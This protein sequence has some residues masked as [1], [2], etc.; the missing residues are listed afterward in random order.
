MYW[1]FLEGGYAK[2]VRKGN[3]KY[4]Y[5]KDKKGQ[6]KE[7]LFDL[8]NDPSEAN[9]VSGV[10]ED[11]FRELQLLGQTMHHRAENKAFL[12]EEEKF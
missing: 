10:R 8:S 5:Q 6:L 4:I 3:W 7:E 9:Y 11:I 1:E 12:T 2:A